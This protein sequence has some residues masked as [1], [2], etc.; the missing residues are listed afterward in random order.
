MIVTIRTLSELS[1]ER[2]EREYQSLAEMAVRLYEQRGD[3]PTVR[4]AILM[5]IGNIRLSGTSHDIAQ[6]EI[7]ASQT[8]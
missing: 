1:P 4:D 8:R 2:R 7:R 5:I 3:V 6:I